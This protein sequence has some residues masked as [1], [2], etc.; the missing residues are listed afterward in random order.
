MGL[1]EPTDGRILVD[2]V[3]LDAQNLSGWR[4]SVAHVPQSVFLADS[5]MA[6]NI[7]LAFDGVNGEFN[8]RTLS[9][10]LAQPIY[11]DALLF[12]K[13]LAGLLTLALALTAIWLLIM[14]LGILRLGIA[15]T[16]EEVARSLLF[17]AMTICFGLLSDRWPRRSPRRSMRAARTSRSAGPG[18]PGRRSRS[19]SSTSCACSAT[20]SSSAAARRT[21]HRSPRPYRWSWSRP[22]PSARA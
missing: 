19:V 1:I 16:G 5:S 18:W 21:C 20:R 14:G 3:E 13:F 2:G 9:R 8:Q 12:G 15:P 6:G 4:R 10:V 11:R 22:G 7:A 17:L